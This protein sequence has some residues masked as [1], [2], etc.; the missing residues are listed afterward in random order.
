MLKNARIR[1]GVKIAT[2][3]ECDK[4]LLLLRTIERKLHMSLIQR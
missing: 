2:I 3:T 4:N 1:I